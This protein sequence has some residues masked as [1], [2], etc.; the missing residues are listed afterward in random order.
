MAK[1]ISCGVLVV[2]AR[3]ELFVGHVTDQTWWDIPKGL[4]DPGETPLGAALREA[5][6][7]AGLHL[8]ADALLDLGCL[9]YLP[10]KDLHLFAARWP[11]PSLDLS[12][13]H[14]STFFHCRKT[15]AA[16]PEAD[17]YTWLSVDEIPTHCGKYLTKLLF[18]TVA[19]RN[20][21]VTLN[22]AG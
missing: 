2:N 8:A 15:G 7:E 20:L 13:C 14:C 9:P 21:V 5:R 1:Q 12:F 17:A 4:L 19:T 16:R 10:K 22:Q 18:D 11:Y 3:Q 6:E